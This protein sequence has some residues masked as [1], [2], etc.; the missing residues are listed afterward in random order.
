MDSR[1][2]AALSLAWIAVELAI[3][4]CHDAQTLDELKRFRAQLAELIDP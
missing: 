1:Y 2:K 3:A 4:H